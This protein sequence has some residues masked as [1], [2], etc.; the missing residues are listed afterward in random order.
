[1]LHNVA[2]LLALQGATFADVISGV[3]YLKHV[4]NLF[5]G[6]IHGKTTRSRY[7]GTCTS[8]ASSSAICRRMASAASGSPWVTNTRRGGLSNPRSRSEEHTSELQSPLN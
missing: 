5:T 8:H 2:S 4:R 1:M 7:S 3:I 6:R